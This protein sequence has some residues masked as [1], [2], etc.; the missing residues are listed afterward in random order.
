[1]RAILLALLLIPSAMG[2]TLFL[3]HGE[4][5]AG[6]PQDFLSE[7][8]DDP[9]EAVDARGWSVAGSPAFLPSVPEFI[10]GDMYPSQGSGAT[11]PLRP[12]PRTYSLND[13]VC[14]PKEGTEMTVAL[15]I[16]TGSE[17]WTGPGGPMV[18]LF[19]ADIYWTMGNDTGQFARG[20]DK[21]IVGPEGER[22]WLNWTAPVPESLHRM[23][24]Q[25]MLDGYASNFFIG[26]QN[27]TGNS[28]ISFVCEIPAVLT[29]LEPER[30]KVESPQT[31][32]TDVPN[33]A[34]PANETPVG[35]IAPALLLIRR[36]YR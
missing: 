1:M 26:S 29:N 20:D 33:G 23:D 14:T 17:S 15:S 32:D 9:R 5:R 12:L 30:A 10:L 18:D 25:V 27:S 22:F 21:R 7:R 16:I 36:L 28:Q 2:A 19:A 11:D 3:G 34:T 24:F 13:E 8:Q 6:E 31:E 35:F 4:Y